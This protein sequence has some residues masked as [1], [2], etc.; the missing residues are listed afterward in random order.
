M[1]KIDTS[2]VL[3]L[4]SPV[5]KI[6][7]ARRNG[8]TVVLAG[9]DPLD[10]EASAKQIMATTGA[11][12]VGPM[13]DRN[14]V[15]G[16]ATATLEMVQ[17]ADELYGERL[18]AIVAPSATGGLL[19]GAAIVCEGT[20]TL[21]FGCEPAKGGPGLFHSLESGVQ[22][23]P[24][25]QNTVADGL[26]ASTAKGNFE[27]IRQKRLGIY[28]VSEQGIKDAW[29][30][31]MEQLKMIVE[32]SSAVAIA[33]VLFNDAFRAMLAEQKKDWNIGIILTGGNT[34]VERIVFELSA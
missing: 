3:P 15:L 12:L 20:Q 21:L 13:D 23:R 2:V 33:T 30:L 29:R 5:T 9:T 26:R 7:G 18:D 22:S 31:T 24:M 8:A 11:T 6:N 34:T 14:I 19:A 27:L 16:Q 1:M 4:T 25:N 28:T 17:Q 32:P 10:R